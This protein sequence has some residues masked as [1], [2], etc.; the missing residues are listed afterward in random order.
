MG[1]R[2]TEEQAL[3]ALLA[4]TRS[5]GHDGVGNCAGLETMLC[6]TYLNQKY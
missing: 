1:V 3:D 2:E 6:Q 4:E 5:D